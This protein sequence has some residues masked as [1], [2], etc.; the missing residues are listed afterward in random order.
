LNN[1]GCDLV[2]VR[3]QAPRPSTVFE[4][5]FS[6]PAWVSVSSSGCG[7][8][9][10]RQLRGHHGTSKLSCSYRNFAD[11]MRRSVQEIIL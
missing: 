7:P 4:L 1:D 5:H 9:Q 8:C 6:Q 2:V 11:E 10:N 3:T